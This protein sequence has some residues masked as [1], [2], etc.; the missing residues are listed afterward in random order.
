VVNSF[1]HLSIDITENTFTLGGI[2]EI[3]TPSDCDLKLPYRS[4]I[5]QSVYCCFVLTTTNKIMGVPL[6]T[7]GSVI[8]F[9]FYQCLYCFRL[10]ILTL[11]GICNKYSL[12]RPEYL[13]IIKHELIVLRLIFSFPHPLCGI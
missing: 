2:Y 8:S 10:T 5:M 13:N 7:I 11:A 9:V 1:K 4:D 3:C 6:G 12:S